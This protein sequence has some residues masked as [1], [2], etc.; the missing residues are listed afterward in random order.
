MSQSKKN[1]IQQIIR[2]NQAGEYGARRIYQ[3]QLDTLRDANELHE[4]RHM[5]QQ[6][7]EH[8]KFFNEQ[9]IV[10]DVQ[11]TIMQPIWHVGGYVMGALSGL[12]GKE[13]A[14]ACTIA[15]EDVIDTHYSEQLATLRCDFPE[16][17]ELISK[18]EKFKADELAHKDTA[19]KNGGENAPF[20]PIVLRAV[21]AITKGA[22]EISK[23][24]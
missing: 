19:M 5:A 21:K 18:I 22:I 16:E 15:V 2:V 3:G 6:E 17:S 10:H 4:I 11:P 12:F 1:I 24:I 20:Y 7:E 13:M 14:H 9:S 8:L 23:K